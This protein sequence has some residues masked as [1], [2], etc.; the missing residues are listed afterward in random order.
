MELNVMKC[1]DC[2]ADLSLGELFCGECGT[3]APPQSSDERDANA[4][5]P[6]VSSPSRG[7]YSAEISRQNPAC[8]VFL[9]DQSGSMAEPLAGTQQ[10]KKEAAAEFINR[11]LYELVLRCSKAD[12]VRSYF[13]IGVF[14]YGINSEVHSAFDADIASVTQIAE[15]PKRLETRKR[16]MRDGAGGIYEDEFQFPIWLDPVAC[17]E[18]K[19]SLNA[20]FERALAVIAA[21][22]RRHPDSF[23]PVIINLMGSQESDRSPS[24]TVAAIQQQGTWDGGVLVFNCH[25]SEKGEPIAFPKDET[26]ASVQNQMRELYDISS[27]LPKRMCD[28]RPAW[29]SIVEPGARGCIFNADTESLRGFLD[30]VFQLVFHSIGARRPWD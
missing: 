1:T 4:P 27:P 2:S 3:A 19:A 29:V 7:T 21:W 11:F 22:I 16:R 28:N 5:A 30:T 12:G 15:Q 9:V 8:L 14:G 6:V 20:A 23:P 25:I 24:Q 10:Q 18:G 17:G 26:A 13:D